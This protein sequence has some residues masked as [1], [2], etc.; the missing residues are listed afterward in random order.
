MYRPTD[1]NPADLETRLVKADTLQDYI[2]I[3]GPEFLTN[4]SLNNQTC[5]DAQETPTKADPE[6]RFDA[7]V[8][9]TEVKAT[10]MLGTERFPRFSK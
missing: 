10:A 4:A 9:K 1:R 8:M 6:V 7:S 2:W 5:H 3:S